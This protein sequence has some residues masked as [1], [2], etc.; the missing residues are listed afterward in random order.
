MFKNLAEGQKVVPRRTKMLGLWLF[1]FVR[2]KGKQT[3]RFISNGSEVTV[4][5]NI[6]SYFVNYFFG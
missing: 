1:R 3:E 4:Y 6:I 5:A 2:G